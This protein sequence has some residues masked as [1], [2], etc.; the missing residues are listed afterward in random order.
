VPDR[1]RYSETEQLILTRL[2]AVHCSRDP[3][4]SDLDE[5]LLDVT[6]PPRRDWVLECARNLDERGL[7]ETALT[8]EGVPSARILQAGLAQT[9]QSRSDQTVEDPGRLQTTPPLRSQA[10]P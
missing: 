5:L 9:L 1:L 6:P 2:A 4:L 10:A 3:G 8:P 7:I